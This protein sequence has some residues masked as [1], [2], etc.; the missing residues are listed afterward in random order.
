[1]AETTVQPNRRGQYLVLYNVVSC[2]LWFVVLARTGLVL[3]LLGPQNVYPA[4]GDFV[5]W[6]QSLAL[7]EILHAATG[8]D[9]IL[10]RLYLSF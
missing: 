1:M 10:S 6:T 4:V 2:F 5:K 3:V 9:G 7:L 8:K